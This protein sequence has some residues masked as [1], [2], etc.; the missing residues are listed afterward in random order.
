M[1]TILALLG[2][3]LTLTLWTVAAGA[4]NLTSGL[5]WALLGLLPPLLAGVWYSNR[6]VSREL[7]YIRYL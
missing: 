1:K 7:L 6:R 2:V 5:L 4:E 3:I